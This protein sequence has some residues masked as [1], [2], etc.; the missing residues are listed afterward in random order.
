MPCLGSARAAAHAQRLMSAMARPLPRRRRQTC[1]HRG[2]WRRFGSLDMVPSRLRIRA[3]NGSRGVDNL[4]R[5]AMLS[6]A[7]AAA[8]SPIFVA[9]YE[10]LLT[11]ESGILRGQERVTLL[12]Y[13]VRTQPWGRPARFGEI[14]ARAVS[15]RIKYGTSDVVRTGTPGCLRIRICAGD[16]DVD[17]TGGARPDDSAG[18][19]GCPCA[20]G[21]GAA[22]G[23]A[24]TSS[25][26]GGTAAAG[27][28]TA[29]HLLAVDQVLPEG[30]GSQ[31]QAGLLH[32]QGRPR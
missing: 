19:Q 22:E 27:G 18:A 25:G 1:R 28:R 9:D 10:A 14:A 7:C 17:R 2:S 5:M 4:G 23:R 24:G 20:Q 3:W 13:L 30:P 12:P 11:A 32:R 8:L 6:K 26:S 16:D 31:R 29:A 21:Q 15:K